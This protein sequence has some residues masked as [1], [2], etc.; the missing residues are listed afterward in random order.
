MK[1]LTNDVAL[2]GE[3]S[4]HVDI[5]P[6]IKLA[7]KA[8]IVIAMPVGPKED[9]TIFQCPVDQD[10]CGKRWLQVGTRAQNLIPIQTMLADKNMI[11]PLN[12]ALTFMV[13]SG[14]LSA[15]ARQ[16][17]TKKAL[18]IGSKYILY[19]DD[20]TLPP[21]L[22]LYTLHNWMERNPNAGAISAVY[23]TREDPCEP[24]VY[25][26]HG[27]GCYWDMPL[28]PGAEPV[29]IFGAGAGFLL[30]R[31]EAIRDVIERMKIE[32]KG[33]EVPIWA[34]E[35]QLPSDLTEP[36]RSILF[37]H[38]IRFCRLLN[39][40]GWPVYIHGQ[41]LCGHFDIATGKTFRM[42]KE[43]PGWKKQR[44]QNINTSD[45]WDDVY[46]S[47]S[48]NTWRQYPEMF[49]KVVEEV[50]AGSAVVELGCGAGILG[51]RLTAQKQVVY[52]GYDISEQAVAYCKA[53]FLNAE[54]LDLKDLEGK[55]LYDLDI[56]IATEVIE[57]LDPDVRTHVL[58]LINHM[59]PDKFIFT[60]PDGGMPPDQVPEHVEDFN[61][62]KVREIIQP[63]LENDWKLTIDK[64]GDEVH[65]IC[66]LENTR[67]YDATENEIA[68]TSEV[69]AVQRVSL[70]DN[71][72]DETEA[73]TQ[74]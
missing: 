16:I 63:Y 5:R 10:G 58:G 47:E 17:M 29:P 52:K 43:A 25:N 67:I 71:A 7:E 8:Q 1:K 54:Q 69:P 50:P 15:E 11:Q 57:H 36:R 53:R 24:L 73:R 62:E 9:S 26:H 33:Q 48:A 68:A 18:R 66:I 27:E 59:R 13:E 22:A 55:Q 41:V 56:V 51:S 2:D 20:D 35:K 39:L 74:E 65:L 19:W 31:L 38:D 49:G 6:Q 21:P 70:D 37:G 14:R 23:V 61:E 45:Y 4:I 44:K 60:V 46:S 40:H 34:D 72:E 64:A 32:N 42:P 30:A 28:G 12:T 3:P